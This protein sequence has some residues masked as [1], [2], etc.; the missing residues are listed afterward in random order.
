MKTRWKLVCLVL[1]GMTANL[2]AQEKNTKPKLGPAGDL[3]DGEST[4]HELANRV[5]PRHGG[6][7]PPSLSEGLSEG[8]L[9]KADQQR[10]S[11]RSPVKKP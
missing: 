6:P 10:R 2:F 8:L 1:F 9:E 7:S 5:L 11:E 4:G 3:V